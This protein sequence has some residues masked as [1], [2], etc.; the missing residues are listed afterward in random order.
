MASR[1]IEFRQES[2]YDDDDD[3]S[4]SEYK[5]DCCICVS[6][7]CLFWCNV[8][9]LC[10][11]LAAM[12]CTIY[13]WVTPDLAWTGD[14]LAWKF[15][16]FAVF[17]IIIVIIGITGAWDELKRCDLIVCVI[18]IIVIVIAQIAFVIYAFTNE[19]S[20][21]GYLKGVWDD[22]SDALKVK[23]MEAYECRL[24]Q[25]ISSTVKGEN[26]VNINKE[27]LEIAYCKDAADTI[28]YCSKD[29][30]AEA[31][32]AIT[33]GLLT[34]TVLIPLGVSAKPYG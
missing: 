17:L 10:F 9:L 30:Y 11:G 3:Y 22:W 14:E 6:R 27:R 1:G 31:K 34:N 2:R 29:C 20:V 18:L 13:L 33:V 26:D 19:D 23:A 28:D 15:T 4:D 21:Q 12:G 24:Y 32:D 5:E 7:S 16:V 25:A 8:A